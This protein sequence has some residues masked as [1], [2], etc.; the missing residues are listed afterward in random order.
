MVKRG[1]SLV[2]LTIFLV[3]VTAGALLLIMQ[4]QAQFRDH[5]DDGFGIVMG[6]A[7]PCA[8]EVDLSQRVLSEN[9]TYSII[10]NTKNP[11]DADCQSE[12]T[13]LAPGFDISPRKEEQIITAKAN[14]RGSIVWIVTP[15]EAG[16][17]EIAVTDGVDTVVTGVTVT[18]LFGLT[19]VQI[20][21][22]AVVGSILGPM[23][24]IPWWLDR[25]QQRKKAKPP[26]PTTSVSQ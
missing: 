13:L 20:Q 12:V 7:L 9:K 16:E 14:S 3:A 5:V 26:M 22:L 15:D 11:M 1:A 6:D 8:W 18:N 24:S 10:V 4:Q 25:L 19:A 23:L 21:M 2:G 17:Y